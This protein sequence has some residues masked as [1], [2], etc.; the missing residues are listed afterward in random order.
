MASIAGGHHIALTVRDAD[1]SAEW[2]SDLLG[3]QVVMSGED[4]AVKFRVLACPNSGWVIGLREYAGHDHDRFDEFRTG[5]DHFAFSVTSRDDLE[6]WDGELTARAVEHSPI[7][8]TPI[9]Q[10]IVF[11]DPDN[12]QLE[13]WL[14]AG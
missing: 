12:I 10:V 6:A 3:M 1:R 7:A 9:G 13:F 4:D 11:R 8:E 2:Y 5:L 14:P